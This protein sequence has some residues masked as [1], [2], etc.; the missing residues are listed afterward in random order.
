MERN[1]FVS[2]VH[3]KKPKGRIMPSRCG[4]P[5]TSNRK[6][7][8]KVEHIFAEQ[9]DRMDLLLR[10]LAP[11]R[12][13]SEETEFLAPFRSGIS[14]LRRYAECTGEIIPHS[15]TSASIPRPLD[16]AKLDAAS[17][18]AASNLER[19]PAKNVKTV[20]A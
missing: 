17:E 12:K 13:T 4:G 2:H 8:S 19:I 20:S 16:R 7:R 11:A 15:P 9:K 5:P 14:R 6:I 18:K 3:R 10:V 1:G